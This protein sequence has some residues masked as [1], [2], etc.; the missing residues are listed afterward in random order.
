VS[1]RFVRNIVSIA[2]TFCFI[3]SFSLSVYGQSTDETA[4]RNLTEKFFTAFQKQDIDALMSL[5][6]EKSPDY[7]TSKQSFQQSFAANKIEVKSTM[8]DKLTVDD[9]KAILRVV[10]DS[11]AVDVKTGKPASGFGKLNHTLYFIKENGIWKITHFVSSEEDLAAA[12]AVAKTEE[13]GKALYE[14]NKELQTIELQRALIAQGIRLTNQSNYSQVMTISQLALT[15]A[16]EL[17]DQIGIAAAFRNIASIHR[18]Q[19]KYP[20][21][22]E[23]F[24]KSLKISEE[25]GDQLGIS[26]TFDG[27]SN[28]YRAQGH[29]TQALEYGLRSLKIAEEISDKQSI[30]TALATLGSAHY[31]LG[32]YPQ[33]LE[34]QNKSL[35]IR[36][37]IGNKYGLGSTLGDMGNTY[38]TQGDYVQALE[39]Y[40]QSLKIKEEISDQ[41]GIANTLN[42]LSL[43]FLSQGRFAEALENFQR[44]LKIKEEIGDKRGTGSTVGNLGLAY[45]AQGNYVQ[46]LEYH[47]RSLKI[48]EELGNQRGIAASLHNIA[49]AYYWQDNYAPALEYYQQSLKI[50]E[51]IGDKLG[52]S[53]SVG[54]IAA[55]YQRQGNYEKALEYF[56]KSLKLREEIGNKSGIVSDLLYLA[57]INR[58]QGNYAEAMGQVDKAVAINRQ[59]GEGEFL[60]QARTTEGQIHRAL[61]QFDLAQKAFTEAITLIETLRNQIAGGTQQSQ[62][63]FAT[64]LSP[65]YE[66]TDLLIAKNDYQEALNFSERSKGRALLDVFDRRKVSI[67]KAM[68]VSEQAREKALNAE[69]VSLNSQIYREKQ[70]VKPD[71]VRLANLTS[72]LEK[73]RLQMD[74][75]QTNLYATHPELRIKR[76]EIRPITLAESAS[77]IPDNKTALLEF[78]VRENQAYL[79]ILTRS[80]K[81]M[82][83]KPDLQF[84]K[85][86]IKQKDLE[87]LTHRFNQRITSRSL[88]FKELAAQLYALLIKPVQTQLRNINTLVIVPDGVLWEL[89]FQAL[90]SAPN[91]YL[92]QDYTISY[93]PSLTVLKEMYSL[94]TKR[95]KG[96]T[97][98]KTL[99]ALGNPA[100][101]TQTAEKVTAIFM[102]E[103]LLPLPEAER[104][105]K[106]LQQIYGNSN[107]RVY[108]GAEAGEERLKQEAS[109]YKI[110]HLAT[111][112]IVNDASPLYSCLV[113]SQQ[114]NNATDDGLLEA[115]EIMKM[116]LNADLVILSAC[117]TA[118]GKVGAGE[119]MIGLAWSLFVAGCPTTVVSQWKVETESN[120]KLMVAFHKNLTSNDNK[121]KSR[122]SKAEALRQAALLLM[123]NKQYSHPFYWAPFVIIGDAN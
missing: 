84:Y 86:N 68:S 88:G 21:A 5:W 67:T 113:L 71:E 120:T 78:V 72:Q 62:E 66:M 114:Q 23:Y 51:E 82:E 65:Y 121:A 10:V 48:A 97:Q 53:R 6:N 3:S 106:T 102:D 95:T 44:S 11:D 70:G 12:I 38:Y 110:L 109:N 28:V 112:G 116:D 101:G 20:Q 104:Q 35:K 27:I 33:A 115:W 9:D 57:T 117:D 79:F 22:M 83:T 73:I 91:R 76:G 17:T 61:N 14:A 30:G 103:K 89:P 43:L 93:A 64:K 29:S 87:D 123:K 19:G 26:N 90:L 40:Q 36:E 8:M 31:S 111:H 45:Q 39:Y 118:R 75:F 24:Q 122:I 96:G 25:I 50:K 74:A 13:E 92:L 52:I 85:V 63:F 80:N 55:V 1:H 37:E 81:G 18:L 47:Q 41:S 15:L 34:Y 77:L 7:A 56:Q 54:G 119:G 4:L 32:N 60:W 94:Q 49:Y 99:L 59:V 100:I 98:A 2:L 105:V 58:L 42:N 108:I 69:M 107:S 16:Q 46:A